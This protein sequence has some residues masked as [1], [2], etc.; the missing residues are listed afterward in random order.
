MLSGKQPHFS[1]KAPVIIYS[2]DYL[3]YKNFS[4]AKQL[5]NLKQ[6]EAS[7]KFSIQKRLRPEVSPT[8][9]LAAT[10][11]PL[12]NQ[13]RSMSQ[14]SKSRISKNDL[15]DELDKRF[16]VKKQTRELIDKVVPAY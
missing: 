8:Y 4:Q 14:K 1:G 16:N 2:R 5:S 15:G 7:S 13:S 10:R 6:A 3:S 9:L 11:P 12:F